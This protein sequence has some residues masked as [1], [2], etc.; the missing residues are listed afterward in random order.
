[1]VV[2]G[3]FSP[4]TT[5]RFNF[6]HANI[7]RYCNRPFSNVQEMNETL[8]AYWNSCVGPEDIIYVLGDFGFGNLASILSKLQGKKHLIIGSHD[9]DTLKFSEC[10]ESTSQMKE[11]NIEGCAITLC[12][13]CMRVWPKSHFNSIHLF[14]H[15]HNRLPPIGK[16][17]DV[18]VDGN[19]FR[20]LSF[21]EIKIIMSQRPDNPN[22][23]DSRDR[24]K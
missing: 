17:H 19:Q 3:Y 5:I 4:L 15:S 16:S 18:G 13:Y 7:I 6:N 24:E 9:R 8:I 2:S 20:P 1:M 14:G 11:L 23:V 22:L 21:E 12:H 10:F